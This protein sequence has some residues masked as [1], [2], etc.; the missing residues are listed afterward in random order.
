LPIANKIPIG[1]RQLA[2]GDVSLRLFVT[3]VL[4]ATPAEFAE[5]EPIGS[6]LFVLRRHVVAAFAL[7][8]LQHN[9]IAWH[10]SFPI[11]DCQFS[12]LN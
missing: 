1:D 9:V 7:T 3:S 4:A 5:L 6:R 2:I 10:Y 11:S 12:I 8:A